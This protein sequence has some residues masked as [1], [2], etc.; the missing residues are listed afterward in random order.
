[1]PSSSTIQLNFDVR[2]L[3]YTLLLSLL[4]GI[5][6]CSAPALQA[7]RPDLMMELKARSG[8]PVQT[9]QRFKLRKLLVVAQVALSLVSLIGAGLF[10][11]SLYNAQQITPGLRLRNSW[12]S[13]STWA[14]RA[15]GTR[16][17][18]TFTGRF[19]NG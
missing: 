7:G 12:S 6:F 18:G 8:Q 4:T 14:L 19:R 17:G 13:P 3:G 15:T 10:L 16:A 1:M 5:I 11:R 9:R 2:V